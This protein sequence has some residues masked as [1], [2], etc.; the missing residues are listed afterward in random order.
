MENSFKSV[1]ENAG[2]VLI[3]LPNNPNLDQV[4]S[5][6]ALYISLGDSKPTQIVSVSP[7]TVSFNRLISVDK[8]SNS[9]GNK[10]MV[11]GFDNYDA[12]GIERVSYDIVE[13]KFKL[14]VIPKSGVNPP[15][16]GQVKISYEGVNADTVILFGGATDADFPQLST[17][18]LEP[19]KM[20]HIGT[21]PLVIDPSR[22]VFT[23][24][25]P[26]AS[27][28]ELT[29]FLMNEA[30][31][32][33]DSETATNLLM[34]IEHATKNYRSEMVTADTFEVTASLIRM[35]GRRLAGE[36]V[37]KTKFPQGAIPQDTPNKYLDE[38]VVKPQRVE[39]TDFADFTQ[40]SEVVKKES[41]PV[42]KPEEKKEED[43]AEVVENPPDEWL[44]PKV[45]RG[46]SLG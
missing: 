31:L 12:N 27:A 25:Q 16:E 5:A 20:Y 3:F 9:A 36:G 13:N 14:T 34:G 24:A 26:M 46:T 38:S 39:A 10:N 28:S 37:D 18:G 40:T 30:Q 6:L 43:E 35:G 7:M 21:Q 22:V 44:Q 41:I 19:T 45:Y 1:I 23:F 2:S 42:P 4:A 11:I 15:H 29:F 8:I 32:P 17:K 33:I